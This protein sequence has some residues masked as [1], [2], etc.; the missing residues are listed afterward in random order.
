MWWDDPHWKWVQPLAY[1][2]FAA[3]GGFL[4]HL[5]R[6]IDAKQKINWLRAALEGV[7]AGFVGLLVMLMC[8]A[9]GFSS[10]WTG[11]VVGVCGWLGANV[12]IR[13]LE[14]IVRRKLGITDTAPAPLM[15]LPDAKRP[16]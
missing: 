3:V 1:A 13:I 2:L 16:E 11:V 8:N 9:M 4:G 5:L 10:Q 7:A 14:K 6:A 12:T 15:E